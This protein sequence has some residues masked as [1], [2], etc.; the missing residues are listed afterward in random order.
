MYK[1]KI[2]NYKNI[3][4]FWNYFDSEDK[5]LFYNCKNK[6]ILMGFKKL[7]N[8]EN[9]Y[10]FNKYK[11]IFSVKTFFDEVKSGIWDGF[12]SENIAFTYYLKIK[13]DKQILYYCGEDI[14]V[15]DLDFSN[16]DRYIY[17]KNKDD[18]LSW[19]QLFNNVHNKITNGEIKKIVISREVEFNLSK[20]VREEVIIRRLLKENNNDF[21]FAY[22]KDN[23]CFLGAT[24]EVLVEKRKNKVIS[25]AVA[26]T[27]IKDN[28][29]S[30]EMLLKDKKN[31]YEQGIVVDH[32]RNILNENGKNLRVS[33]REVIETK[34]L[35]HLHTTL[36][37]ESDENIIEWR[38]RLH[39][40]AAIGGMPRNKSLKILSENENHER[41]LYSSPIG[42][43][44][45][46]G[47]GI[48]IVALRSGL[49]CK[50]KLY[51]YAGCGIVD[52][53]ECKKEYLETAG[54]MQTI[55]QCL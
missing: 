32:I 31:C 17:E 12:K 29:S 54:K 23:K 2:V 39:P 6:E 36:S 25:H 45:D 18:Y 38:N 3:F 24:P 50:D 51:A 21:V 53:S 34:N 9:Y 27:L 20:E 11:F 35:Y 15:A 52:D 10:D 40:T 1:E 22:S 43:I 4:S 48:F 49:L 37:V 19:K 42:I 55:L 33:E 47:D 26:G 16:K 44:S 46:D 14:E 41:G 28:V 7:R 13:D 8:V 5:F 30:A